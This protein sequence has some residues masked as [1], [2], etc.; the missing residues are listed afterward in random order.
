MRQLLAAARD[1]A[2][3]A[4]QAALLFT[5][6][7]RGLQLFP[8]PHHDARLLRAYFGEIPLAGFFAAGELGPIGGS[9][10]MHGFTASTVL[11]H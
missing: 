11:F 9:N 4:T 3:A 10:F 7:G 8:E 6:N 5:C 2:P 1:N